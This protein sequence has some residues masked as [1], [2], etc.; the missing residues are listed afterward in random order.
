M[1]LAVLNRHGGIACFDQDV[2][3]N[4]VGGVKIT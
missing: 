3:V 4:A 2:F 1:L